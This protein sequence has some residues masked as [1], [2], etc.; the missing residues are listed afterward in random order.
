[1]DEVELLLSVL[2]PVFELHVCEEEFLETGG[3]AGRGGRVPRWRTWDLG[4][5]CA[6]ELRYDREDARRALYNQAERSTTRRD[7]FRLCRRSFAVAPADRAMLLPNCTNLLVKL[8]ESQLQHRIKRRT[9]DGRALH[10]ALNSTRGRILFS[11]RYD[12]CSRE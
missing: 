10:S 4:V 7:W 6:H 9:S 3:S 11:Y 1:V 2:D 5:A 12:S 8:F